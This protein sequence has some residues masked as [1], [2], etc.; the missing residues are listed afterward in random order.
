MYAT[1][2][3]SS[4]RPLKRMPGV[5]RVP[6]DL[7]RTVA[8]LGFPR[9]KKGSAGIEC[10][11]TAFF[12][13]YKGDAYVVTVKHVA[14]S[15]G[16]APFLLRLNRVDGG[17]DN[18]NVD[19]DMGDG[20]QITWY[21]HPTDET[22]DLAV[23]AFPYDLQEMGF[24]AKAIPE[25][26]LAD[27]GKLTSEFVGIGDVTYT[28]GLFRLL[29]GE[30]RNLQVVHSGSIALLPSDE[31]VPVQ[32]WDQPQSGG[33]KYVEAFLVESQSLEGLSGSPVFVRPTVLLGGLQTGGR[34]HTARMGRIDLLLLG[35]WQGAWDAKPD[36]VLAVGR[37]REMRVPVGMGV[38]VPA[39]KLIEVLEHPKLQEHRAE[40][41]RR[42]EE[43]GVASL[44]SAIPAPR[45]TEANP[46]HRE[47][48]NSLLEQAAKTPPQD[49]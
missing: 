40:L 5:M 44:D 46:T 33:S 7:R 43:D 20:P 1:L 41:Q 27:S 30:T 49:D 37:G 28:V 12:I 47:D 42:R 13:V 48:F 32:D 35:V 38:V 14:Q 39:T 9:K 24:D 6:E 31:R 18:V 3:P 45:S 21:G 23:S 2:G 22:V 8:F 15:I 26:M 10:I 25:V 29:A 16:D 19:L 34:E 36:E 4:P 17:S 11:G